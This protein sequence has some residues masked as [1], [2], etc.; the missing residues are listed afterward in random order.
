MLG[1]FPLQ[2]VLILGHLG[3]ETSSSITISDILK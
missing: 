3:K 2:K 1:T